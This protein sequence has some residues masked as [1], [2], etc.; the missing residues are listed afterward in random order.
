[1]PDDV[2]PGA[3]TGQEIVGVEHL[4][5]RGA[6]RGQGVQRHAESVQIEP[7]VDDELVLDFREAERSF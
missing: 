6:V 3:T 2:P 4:E 1:M 7:L 5:R